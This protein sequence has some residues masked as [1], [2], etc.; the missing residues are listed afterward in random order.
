METIDKK[1]VPIEA[2]HP[3]ELIKDE[4][5]ARGMKK[6]ELAER[7]G[8]KA[9]NLSRFLSAKENVTPTMALKLEEAFGISADYWMDLQL[10][11][12]RDLEAIRKRDEKETQAIQIEAG[13]SAALN[14][15]MLYKKLSLDGYRFFRD[16][17]SV[18]FDIFHVNNMEGL[19][20]C[21]TAQGCFKKS[22]QLETETKNVS[23]WVLLA[24]HAC[25]KESSQMSHYVKG[26]ETKAAQEIASL[27]NAQTITESRIKAILEENGIGYRIVEKFEK[28]PVDAYSVIIEGH[29]FIVV[30]HRRNNMD[31]LVFDILHECG[32]IN[33][34]LSDGGSFVS[35]NQDLSE[36]RGI[37]QEANEYAKNVLIP[38]TVWAK[39]IG[40]GSKSLNP[41]NLIK[42]ITEEAKNNGISP[43]IA[44]WRFKY[45]TGIYKIPG[46]NSYPIR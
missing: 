46:Y 25:I 4:I 42:V 8:M 32:H 30:S 1:F 29:P 15:R 16:R 33:K 43:T 40:R 11:Y 3:S 31:M 21:A 13:L 5:K 20:S 35:Y 9:S 37:E 24:R 44:A 36:A 14:L 18:L 41:Y 39:I 45:E 28:T 19:L 12:E 17:L 23:T 38:P 2:I 26:N 6:K 34:H 10:S 7:L 27:T 22:E